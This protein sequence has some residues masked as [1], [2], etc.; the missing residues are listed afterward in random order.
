[1]VDMCDHFKEFIIEG[2]KLNN[3]VSEELFDRIVAPIN[4][5]HPDGTAPKATTKRS[6]AAKQPATKSATARKKS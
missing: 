4:M 3:G 6:T 1:M 2:A 5:T